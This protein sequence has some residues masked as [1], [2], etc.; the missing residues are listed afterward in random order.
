MVNIFKTGYEKGMANKRISCH[1]LVSPIFFI[2]FLLSLNNADLIIDKSSFITKNTLYWFFS[3][4]PQVFGALFAF[5]IMMILL[6]KQRLRREYD[7]ICSQ[8]RPIIGQYAISF[9]EKKYK[10][11][12]IN[13]QLHKVCLDIIKNCPN[14]SLNKRNFEEIETQFSSIE[15]EKKDNLSYLDSFGGEMTLTILFS[16]FFLILI[17]PISKSGLGYIFATL[18]IYFSFWSLF[19]VLKRLRERIDAL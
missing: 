7:S 8:V 9:N 2:V 17:D 15:Q 1:I 11:V 18:I 19:M 13:N 6:I 3:T 14:N 5:A 4:V 16:L 12:L 10:G